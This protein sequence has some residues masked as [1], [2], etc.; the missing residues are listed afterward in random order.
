MPTPTEP[1]QAFCQVCTM[2]Q[3]AKEVDT[4]SMCLRCFEFLEIKSLEIYQVDANKPA[5]TIKQ[6]ELAS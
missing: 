6:D 2:M 1:S 5:L 4:F 3:C